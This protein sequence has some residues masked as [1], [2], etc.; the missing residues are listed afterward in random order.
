MEKKIKNEKY[1]P[2]EN[3]WDICREF[4]ANDTLFI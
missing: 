3:F 2:A 4:V 1:L